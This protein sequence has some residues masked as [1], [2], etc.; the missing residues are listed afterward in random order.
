MISFD[1]HGRDWDCSDYS[2]A[3]VGDSGPWTWWLPLAWQAVADPVGDHPVPPVPPVRRSGDDDYNEKHA[4]TLAWWSPLFHLLFFAK[5]WARPDLGLARWLDLGQPDDDPVL[6]LVKQWWGSQIADVLAWAGWSDMLEQ[7]AAQVSTSVHTRLTPARLPDRW[8]D[9]R[10]SPRW[11][12]AWGGGGDSMHLS[13]HVLTPVAEAHDNAVH[14]VANPEGA[15]PARAALMLSQYEGWYATLSRLGPALP[16]RA[17]GR[18]WHVYV[19]VRPLG[20]LGSYRHSHQTGRWFSG[21]HR[22]HQ[23]GLAAPLQKAPGF[24]GGTSS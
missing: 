16:R 5:G 2:T 20:W 4:Y 17:D 1:T 12:N 13:Y 3:A 10:S 9:R 14:L 23:L 19:V 15:G 21:R 6:R 22:W 7:M 11:E 24:G 8:A 18:S